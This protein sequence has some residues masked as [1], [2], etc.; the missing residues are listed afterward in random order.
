MPEKAINGFDLQREADHLLVTRYAPASAVV[1]EELKIL[2]VYGHT[3][4]YLQLAPGQA[5]LNLLTMTHE[6]LRPNLAA[7]I[8][9]ARQ[10]G[11]AVKQEGI[12]VIATEMSYDVTLE[13]I[14]LQSPF[15][16][17]SLLVVFRETTA[18]SVHTPSMG[19]VDNHPDDSIGHGTVALR[20]ATLEEELATTR[21][22]MAAALE[23]RDAAIEELQTANEEIRASNEELQAINEELTTANEQIRAA[24]EF[25]EAIVETVRDPLVV[26]SHCLQIE[27]A[28]TAFYQFFQVTPQEIEEHSLSD[29]GGG[30]WD[31]AP[32]RVLLEGVITANQ[33]FSNFEVEA[34][35][36]TIGHKVL[37]L[38]ACPLLWEGTSIPRVLL[39]MED[40]TER[41]RLE[42]IELRVHTEK[43]AR[44]AML[45]RILDEMP[46]SVYLVRGPDARLV[47]ANRASATLWGASWLPDQPMAEFLT[48]NGI[49]IFDVDGRPLPL[50]QF[51]TLRAV[52]QG[53]TVRQHQEVIRQ[54]DGTALPVLV[55]AVGLEASHLL[56]VSSSS[57]PVGYPTDEK[58]RAAL[59]VHQDV[60][61]LKEAE[62]LKEEFLSIA[63]HELRTPL[64]VLRGFAQTLL[65]QTE[66]GRGPQLA[67]WQTEALQ[68]IDVAVGRLDALTGDLLDVARLQAGRFVL[69]LEDADLVALTQRVVK[70]RQL[71]TQRHLLSFQSVMEQI[72]VVFDRGRIEQVLSNLLSNAIKYSPEGGSILVTLGQEDGTNTILLSVQD[73]GIGIPAREQARL[74]G[75][76]IRA[77]NALNEGIGGTGLG[78]Y[79]CR[80][81]I[82][83][84]GGHIWFTSKE[85]AG[86]TFYIS[87]PLTSEAPRTRQLFIQQT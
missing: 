85:G 78:L 50:A 45:Q 66:R 61:A 14:P 48:A 3:G 28:N 75:R 53:E 40:L 8:K 36:P 57:S 24:Q 2:H 34:T 65:V 42:Q 18:V 15:P 33:S 46:S 84:H 49:R 86:S 77:E 17:A 73:H 19:P 67:D 71:T 59:V 38:N 29:F 79:L 51:A 43:E 74:F 87:L 32:L 55:N 69:H 81:L 26:L 60:S 47:L 56:P 25:A 1:D 22:A 63:A 80:E 70:E 20:I 82:E 31:K 64:A 83:W 27:R 7:A 4:S 12:T 41:R 58:E 72:V 21:A 23:E 5:N 13:V 9:Q 6:A 39:A 10:Q 16:R 52:G 44:L 54:P 11:T 30:Q 76:F 35:F 37:L 68:D 62:R